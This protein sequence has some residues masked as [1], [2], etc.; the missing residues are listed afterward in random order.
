[1]RTLLNKYQIDDQYN[2]NY[3]NDKQL[4]VLLDDGYYNL[5]KQTFR[6]EKPKPQNLNDILKLHIMM[7][8]NIT[9][10]ELILSS[11]KRRK[12]EKVSQFELNNEYKNNQKINLL[13]LYSKVIL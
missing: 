4:D 10:A 12:G 3:G 1:M 7:L 13:A 6:T 8:K 5:I 2:F 9:P 11:R